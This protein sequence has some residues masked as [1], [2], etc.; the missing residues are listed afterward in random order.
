VETPASKFFSRLK[1]NPEAFFRLLRDQLGIRLRAEGKW[2]K[3]SVE[4]DI[5][6]S[7]FETPKVNEVFV[8]GSNSSGKTFGAG[9]AGNAYLFCRQPSYV[10]YLSTKKEQA[11]TQ[12]WS[13]FLGTYNRLRTWCRK[14]GIGIPDPMVERVE[15][16]PDWWA[17]V[18]AGQG[19]GEK[20]KAM[21]WSG[22]H[23]K[24]QLFIVDEAPGI[25]DSVHE[26]ITG[27]V[28]GAHNVL[29]AQGNPLVR[30]GWWYKGQ[31][32]PIPAHR[33]VFKI[34]AKESPNYIHRLWADRIKEE[35][36]KY[37]DDPYIKTLPNGEVEFKELIPG[38]AGMEW[39]TKIESDPETRPG[40][41]YHD[42]H[43]LGEFPQGSEW[44]LLPWDDIQKAAE[45]SHGWQRC[46]EA[47]GFDEW[48]SLMSSVGRNEA[49]SRIIEYAEANDIQITLPDFNKLAVG[50]DVA[51]GGGN[52][53]VISVLAGPKL[54]EQRIVDGTAAV[55]L[56]P[57]IEETLEDYEIWSCGIDKPGVGVAPVAVLQARGIEVLE[58][59]GGVPADDA[60][61][62]Q[63]YAD[64][65]SEMA[66]SLR[67]EFV[68]DEI[69]IPDDEIL[70]QQL[71]SI[72][73]S[74]TAGNKVKVPKPAKSPDRF[75]SLRIAFWCQ[76]YGDYSPDVAGQQLPRYR[77]QFNL[78]EW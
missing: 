43:V 63:E 38:L 23:N 35:T 7:L 26:M 56:P 17:R 37:P 73:W 11:K 55:Q 54:L 8:R 10:M 19:R 34:S 5:L 9:I 53:S 74:Y 31:Q 76:R 4:E 72:Q 64:L 61:D 71:G 18:Y 28:T 52:L 47:L 62:R 66:W 16:A 42:G 29:L 57:L 1:N 6:R 60:D 3:W 40:A 48:R 77:A 67:G 75:D 24:Y 59:K 27:N 70:K 51:D 45:R 50:V 33:K 65:N 36:G 21:G 68:N 39:I 32:L 78:D 49:I 2:G 14:N 13:Q 22:F 12:A 30:A 20:D 44:G 46:I 69:E 25:P 41:P 15:F 58:Y